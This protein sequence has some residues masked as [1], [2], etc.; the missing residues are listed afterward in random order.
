MTEAEVFAYELLDQ[1]VRIWRCFSYDKQ[2]EF[3]GELEGRPVTELAAYVCSAHLESGWEER[4]RKTDRLRYGTREGQ[5]YK[6]QPPLDLLGMEV[7]GSRVEAVSLPK[8]LEKIGKYAFYNCHKL[9]R[10]SFS[11]GI[12][13]LGAGLFT[14]C[15]HVRELDVEVV[16]DWPSCLRQVLTELTEELRVNYREPGGYARLLF[17]EF[18]EEGVENTPARILMTQVHGS[19]LHFRNCF[20]ETQ[21]QFPWYD[22]RFF[23]ARSQETAAFALELALSRLL[24]P[25]GLEEK[26]REAYEAYVKEH[27]LEAGT[28]FLEE[29]QKIR[30]PYFQ[31]RYH[32]GGGLDYF[33]W[34]LDNKAFGQVI[35]PELLRELN[36]QAQKKQRP[37]IVSYLMDRRHQMFP[38][39]GRSFAL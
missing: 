21:F 18:Y 9:E 19:G 26:S 29:G 28:F 22:E 4:L 38:Q 20:L 6:G 14:G 12:Q 11:S 30:S 17:P 32:S 37:E 10:V 39:K 2:V 33:S 7:C 35:T 13:D 31:E 16:R 5:V 36:G 23:W 1:G 24:Y 8:K 15:H 3:P 25:L 34:L 27:F